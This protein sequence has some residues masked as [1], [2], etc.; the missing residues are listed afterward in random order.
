MWEILPE[1]THEEQIASQ[2]GEFDD[3][4]V[5]LVKLPGQTTGARIDTPFYALNTRGLLDALLAQ[6]IQSE[7]DLKEWVKKT[8]SVSK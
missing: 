4:P 6:K 7:D 2:G 1:W 5:Y 3:R 8:D